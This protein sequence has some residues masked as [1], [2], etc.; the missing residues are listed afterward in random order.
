M[1][2]VVLGR[3]ERRAAMADNKEEQQRRGRERGP[4][5][6]KVVAE[7]AGRRVLEYAGMHRRRART[8]T[9]AGHWKGPSLRR[10][11]VLKWKEQPSLDSPGSPEAAKEGTEYCVSVPLVA[12]V[13][14]AQYL[15]PLELAPVQTWST[16]AAKQQHSL[17]PGCRRGGWGGGGGGS[18]STA[19]A[20]G[21]DY[22]KKGCQQ[23]GPALP[24]SGP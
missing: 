11:A 8:T 6:A 4:A 17:Q 22:F 24:C 2:D 5:S 14:P 3:K 13:P 20:R 10:V 19:A 18:G 7:A 12:K 9:S 21:V 15:G 1:A 16:R 23:R